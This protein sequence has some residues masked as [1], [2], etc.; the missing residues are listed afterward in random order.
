MGIL[1][2]IQG[3]AMIFLATNVIQKISEFQPTITQ[4]FLKYDVEVKGLV[5]ASKEL[6]DL[7][8]GIMLASFLIISA[9]AHAIVYIMSDATINL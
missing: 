6:F 5:T 4:N 8:F 1:H 2:F 9:L 3:I 7:S